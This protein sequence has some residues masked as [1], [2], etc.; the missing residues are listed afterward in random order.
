MRPWAAHLSS[1][2]RLCRRSL[3]EKLLKIRPAQID[4]LL[5]SAR[6]QH[7]KKGLAVTRPRYAP[8]ARR[9]H[10][11]LS[12]VGRVAGALPLSSED[13]VNLIEQHFRCKGS[14]RLLV[15]SVAVIELPL[16]VPIAMPIGGN[17]KPQ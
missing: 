16:I 6:V 11:L 17:R 4:R 14:S 13:T 15:F 2:L 8:A 7:P 9:A 1:S 3:T 10:A 12:G 5:R